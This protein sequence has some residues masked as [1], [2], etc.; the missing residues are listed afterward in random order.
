MKTAGIFVNLQQITLDSRL[1]QVYEGFICTEY[2]SNGFTVLGCYTQLHRHNSNASW[3]SAYVAIHEDTMLLIRCAL[4][5][6]NRAA[7]H[8]DYLPRKLHKTVVKYKLYVD[9]KKE[10]E[11]VCVLSRNEQKAHYMHF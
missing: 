2:T 3:W 5:E 4:G 9:Y 10:N 7:G 11:K 6:V 8:T 1:L